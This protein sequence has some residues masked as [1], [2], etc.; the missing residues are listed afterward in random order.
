[1]LTVA[2]ETHLRKAGKF[3]EISFEYVKKWQW[4]GYSSREGHHSWLSGRNSSS[5][6]RTTIRYC[7][8]ILNAPESNWGTPPNPAIFRPTRVYWCNRLR[9][10]DN[11]KWG[12]SWILQGYR[13]AACWCWCMCQYSIWDVW[14]YEKII[15]I[16][17]WARGT[18]RDY[19]WS[20]ILY[21][22][23]CCWDCKYYCRLCVLAFALIEGPVELIRIRLQTQSAKA[24]VYTGPIDCI[25]KIYKVGGLRALYRGM[26]PTIGREGH[27]M[28]YITKRDRWW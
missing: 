16:T 7:Q 1:M 21:R 19:V 22:W 15:P 27:G 25:K 14:I 3:V 24:K 18:C 12:I 26:G 20:A 6:H 28:G 4:R 11:R 5:S 13:D 23:R 17:E 2:R 10:K 9:Q 8:G